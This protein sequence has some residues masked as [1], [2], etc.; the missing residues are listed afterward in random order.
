M[1]ARP[2]HCSSQ[3][4]HQ[5]RACVALF[6]TV[7]CLTVSTGTARAA[8][9]FSWSLGPGSA[10]VGLAIATGPDGDVWVRTASQVRRYSLGGTLRWAV[11]LPHGEGS[12]SDASGDLAVLDDGTALT[13]QYAL[14]R[15][16]RV[17]GTGDTVAPLP[18]SITGELQRPYG[19]AR[20][21]AGF[22]LADAVSTRHLS[23]DGVQT[24]VVAGGFP[25]PG[26]PSSL[27][28]VG[29]GVFAPFAQSLYRLAARPQLIRTF[30]NGDGRMEKGPIGG[31]DPGWP[32]T[33]WV[34]DTLDRQVVL[35]NTSNGDDVLTCKAPSDVSDVARSGSTV[36]GLRGTNVSVWQLVAGGGCRSRI[37]VAIV[38]VRRTSAS[39]TAVRYR[40]RAIFPTSTPGAVELQPAWVTLAGS[41]NDCRRVPVRA[42]CHLGQAVHTEGAPAALT[43]RMPRSPRHVCRKLVVRVLTNDGWALATTQRN[44]CS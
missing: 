6:F 14:D 30:G 36:F 3:A 17:S 43:I 24:G 23:A 40:L 38:S 42:R 33:V 41:K 19:I 10:D 13:T 44:V 31:V 7:A 12:N 35:A 8:A 22:V 25:L 11:D 37:T 29:S 18:L 39:R 34:A 1:R 9:P 2:P 20:D 4:G 15:V 21:G 28:V 16:V 32:G 26:A 27:A 5:L